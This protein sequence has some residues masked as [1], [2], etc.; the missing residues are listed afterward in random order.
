VMLVYGGIT[1]R[2][3]D[4]LTIPQTTVATIVV[5][6][7]MLAMSVAWLRWKAQKKRPQQ[8]RAA[9]HMASATSS[10]L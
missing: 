9:S 8:E 7:L 10:R 1:T 2:L 5:T 6:L 4:N 3:K